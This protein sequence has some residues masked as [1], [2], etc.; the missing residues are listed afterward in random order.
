MGKNRFDFLFLNFALRRGFTLIELI[1]VVAILSLMSLVIAQVFFTT[2][3]TNT[4]TELM[5]DV[6]QNGEYAIDNMTRMI[7]SAASVVGTCIDIEETPTPI[8]EITVVDRFGTSVLLT[9]MDVGSPSVARIAS[10][11]GGVTEYLTSESVS[12]VSDGGDTTCITSPL[13]FACTSVGGTPSS[14]GVSFRLRQKNTA[15]SAEESADSQFKSTV[16]IRN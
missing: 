15:Q 14:I 12:L 11:S 13:Q 6:K 1:V 2:M 9:C 3:K 7:Q 4:K 16:T 5:K 10:V 8:D